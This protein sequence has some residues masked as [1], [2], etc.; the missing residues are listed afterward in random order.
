MATLGGK[1]HVC[2]V[3]RYEERSKAM[4]AHLTRR[5]A[6]TSAI[7]AASIA[8]LAACGAKPGSQAAP[9]AQP[10]PA[11]QATSKP[12]RPKYAP[13]TI[14][15]SDGTNVVTVGETKVTFPTTVK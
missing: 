7:L 14:L 5:R 12:V 8:V 9:S 1:A 6:A 2:L 10:S 4:R 13:G 3:V 11:P 15:I